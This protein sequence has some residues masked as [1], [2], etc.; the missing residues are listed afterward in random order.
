MDPLSADRQAA[1]VFPREEV[2]ERSLRDIPLR[3]GDEDRWWILFPTGESGRLSRPGFLTARF[4]EDIF[5]NPLDLSDTPPWRSLAMK[6]VSSPGASSGQNGFVLVVCLLLLAL[7]VVVG[8][9]GMMQVSTGLKISGNYKGSRQAFYA[10]EGGLDYAVARLDQALRSLTP[11]LTFSSPAMSG[12]TFS[13]FSVAANGS[14]YQQVLASG[15]FSGLTAFCSNYDVTSGVVGSDNAAAT[16][17]S[18]VRNVLIPLFQFGIFYEQDLEI[19]PGANMTFAGGRI[20][21]N[22]D[23]YLNPDGSATLSIDSM[24]TTAG[25]LFHARKDR[26]D[27]ERTVRIKDGDDQYQTMT[28][29]S[30]DGSWVTESQTLWD[31]RVQTED[32][33]IPEL[34]L[35]L[36]TA[37]PR[38]ILSTGE[39][40]MYSKA[41]L[42][43]INGVATDKDGN[44]VSLEY[45][46]S[47]GN[48]V[49][50][51]STSTFYDQ[52]EGA[53]VT[54]TNVNV[55]MLMENTSAMASLNDPPE[56]G[57]AG[58]LYVSS[59][60]NAVRL[61][62]GED[63][64]STGFTVATDRPLYIQ[65]NYNLDND[66]AAVVADAVTVLSGSWIDSHSTWNLD[67]RVAS[68]TTVNTAIMGGNKNT[69][70]SQY[71]GGVENFIRFLEKWSGRTLNYSG[72]LVCLWESAQATG[73][74]SYGSYYTAPTR[75]WS[76]GIDPSRLP[77]GTPRVR[78]LEEVS[79]KQVQ[80]GQE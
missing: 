40:S 48:T 52:R 53:T 11:N 41:G 4:S 19:L 35:P 69:T 33:G 22:Q 44:V 45:T 21:S 27:T 36:S 66:P 7:L 30:D 78:M 34:A 18:T 51:I 61:T 71:S 77:P 16:I 17:V 47:D 80:P 70:G 26:T 39:G 74:W 60:S 5:G 50:P 15:P 10:A 46:D 29:D 43:I 31:G 28:I 62:G 9:A 32:H 49:T 2:N 65:G 58:I 6:R 3:T 38:E 57:D 68:D 79:W 1:E 76:Y 25:D 72:S 75:N 73:N 56:G 42:R 37:D 67:N 13:Q 12:F 20:H 59:S 63:I 64:P 23:I 24:I 14:M 55:E 8:T 54:V